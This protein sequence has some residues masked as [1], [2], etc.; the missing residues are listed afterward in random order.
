[1]KS[2]KK[3]SKENPKSTTFT[4][5]TAIIGVLTLFVDQSEILGINTEII[6]WVSFG[7]SVLTLSLTYVNAN[8]NR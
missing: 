2:L 3:V 1:M 5:I 8:L 6:K 7:I 4:A